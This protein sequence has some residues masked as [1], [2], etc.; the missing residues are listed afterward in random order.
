[1]RALRD[2]AQ[3]ARTSGT[4]LIL[5]SPVLALPVEIERDCAVLDLPLPDAAEAGALFDTELAR[6]A[7]KGFRRDTFVTAM[8]VRFLPTESPASGAS[9]GVD[10]GGAELRKAENCGS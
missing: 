9:M 8:N 4:T 7:A 10:H 2:F 1:M 3:A 6:G 5:V